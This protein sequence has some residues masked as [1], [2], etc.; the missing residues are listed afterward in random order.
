[1]NKVELRIAMIRA[2]V[3]P[4]VLAEKTGMSRQNLS[5]KMTGK[6][7]FKLSE[8]KKIASALNLSSESID[9]I[10]FSGEVN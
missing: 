1:M 6:R 2:G 9:L 5:N 3:T 8:I 10:F 4:S 7:E